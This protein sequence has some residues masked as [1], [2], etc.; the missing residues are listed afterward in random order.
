M[1]KIVIKGVLA[2]GKHGVLDF[3]RTQ[4][5]PFTVDMEIWTDVSKACLSD[6]L[7]DTVNY[8]D[9]YNIVK[10]VIETQSFML[11]ER[12][13]FVIVEKVFTYDNRIQKIKIKAVK[14]KA[15]L[16]GQLDHIGVEIEKNRTDIIT[17]NTNV[18]SEGYK[19]VL[20]L[21]SNV[22]DRKQNIE[23]ALESLANCV[24]LNVL[25]KSKLYETTPVGYVNQENFYNAAVLV[26]TTLNPFEL[27]AKVKDIENV[28]GRKKTFKWGPRIIDID[29][30]A[31]QGCTINTNEI[32]I[33]HKEYTQRPFVL[34]P[35]SDIVDV[36]EGTGLNIEL[37]KK[38]ASSTKGL[39]I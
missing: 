5:Q 22:G 25:C 21:G 2:W 17:Q 23:K 28:L 32:T 8:A 12:L 26:K 34:K 14:N 29:I 20:A 15:P 11:L 18:E 37:I 38:A 7:C 36:L 19:A 4:T 30:I 16:E 6:N 33:P 24:G 9:I 10:S 1:D 31:Y 27:F 39:E 35:L 3:E 13:A